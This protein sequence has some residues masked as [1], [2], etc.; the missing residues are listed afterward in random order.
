[1]R[2]RH[3]RGYQGLAFAIAALLVVLM[4][5][6]CSD[7]PGTGTTAGGAAPTIPGAT[8]TGPPASDV[9]TTAGV[10]TTTTLAPL[11]TLAPTTTLPP[12]VTTSSLS[13][14]ETVVGG[15]I[16][17]MGFIDRV[18][19]DGGV[20]H[21]RI[22][23]AEMLTG[24]E[25]LAAFNAAKAAG[26]E[27]ADAT[28]DSDWYISNVN[29]LKRE[30]VVSDSVAITTSTRFDPHGGMNASC[31]WGDFIDFWGPGPFAEGDEYMNERPWTIERDGSTVI[32]ID[33][34]YTE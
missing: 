10:E 8:T 13:T 15:H 22:D 23:Y 5:V 24:A 28:L 25:A 4:A 21:L 7:L 20:R 33:E 17:A 2:L 3:R 1:M 26:L 19:V 29:P 27:P 14:A 6:G 16:V 18:W 30:F 9:T 31:T 12:A 11:T 34:M 32:K